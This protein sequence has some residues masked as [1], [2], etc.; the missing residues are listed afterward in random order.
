MSGD[1]AYPCRAYIMLQFTGSATPP[2]ATKASIMT[3]ESTFHALF[4]TLT[5]VCSIGIGLAGIN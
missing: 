5:P 1:V 2:D 3:F 4:E